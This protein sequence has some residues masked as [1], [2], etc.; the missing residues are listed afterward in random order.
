M[1]KL[2]LI[3]SLVILLGFYTI[4]LLYTNLYPPE[5]E[6]MPKG[7][8]V[9]KD[10]R[11]VVGNLVA[12]QL[13][14]IGISFFSFGEYFEAKPLL[15]L[16]KPTEVEIKGHYWIDGVTRRILTIEG[17]KFEENLIVYE[18]TLVYN[19]I[20][21]SSKPIRLKFKGSLQVFSW[22]NPDFRRYIAELAKVTFE[23]LEELGLKACYHNTYCLYLTSNYP[24]HIKIE[25]TKVTYEINVKLESDETNAFTFAVVGTIAKEGV[26]P[27][28]LRRIIKDP[29][30]LKLKK[31]TW[32]KRLFEKVHKL[33]EIQSKYSLLWKYMWY[34]I[35]SNRVHVK[36]HPVLKNPFTMPS[37]FVFR[38]QWL[39]D[40]A[41][42]A[43]ILSMLDVQVAEEELLNLFEAQKPDGRIPH[44]IFLSK[45]FCKL[46]WK[47]DDYSPW[48]T[49]PPVIAI[50]IDYIVNRGASREFIERAF[51]ALDRYDRWFREYR[52]AD[53]DQLMA[54]VDPLE[55]GWD[56]SVR[57]DKPIAVFKYRTKHYRKLY[58]N[59]RMAPVEAVDL[60]CYIYI[61]RKVLAE[62]ARKL[63]LE[64]LAEEYTKLAE[65]T[66]LKIRRYMW[67]PETNF[68]Y[69]IMEENHEQIKVK[70][71]AAFVILYAGL[72]TKEQ[73][74]KLV[75]HLLNPREF[76]TTFPLPSVSA[77]D[78]KYDPK[79]Y[80]RGRS[81]INM[82]WFTYWGLKKYGFEK[83]ARMLAEKALD[84]MLK[85]FTC[86]EN[87]NSLT[88]EPLGAPDF[89]WSTLMLSIIKDISQD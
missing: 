61:Q 32:I 5:G 59:I 50:A 71:P 82:I 56:D 40:S 69:D 79:G 35:L 47:V 77:D 33:G 34:V 55:S 66:A 68:F 17:V 16:T 25:K 24:M 75:E 64:N 74:E 58:K 81:W 85:T 49:Q 9:L 39:W 48:T 13:G 29:S 22:F 89:G 19:L 65:E 36:Q 12:A 53:K 46:F 42:H 18:D 15:M 52:D 73:A 54:Y 30:S 78:P 10:K 4:T 88:G 1:R 63:G 62:L 23:T 37:K 57:W 41:F 3:I 72:A 43:I 28:D 21:L 86:N 44:E 87:Y 60:N 27:E 76:W 14:D 11:E 51:R 83:E 80:W 45:E 67:D 84:I 2:C 31:F 38:H 7:I 70:T 20:K 26:K 6:I 8:L